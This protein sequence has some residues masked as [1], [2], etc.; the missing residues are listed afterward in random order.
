MPSAYLVAGA[1]VAVAQAY[2][3]VGGLV[4]IAF[5]AAGLSR[6][7]PQARCSYAFR[8]LLVPGL[9]LLWPLV[10]MRWRSLAQGRG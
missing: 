4:A 7:D 5:L 2:L 1:V 6:V 8:P 9:V 3:I 10:L